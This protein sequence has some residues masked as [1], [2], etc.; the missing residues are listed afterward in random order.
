M[1]ESRIQSVPRDSTVAEIGAPAAA[2]Q[3]T[4]KHFTVT[5]NKRVAGGLALA[6]VRK[7]ITRYPQGEPRISQWDHRF[8]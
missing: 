6:T 7:L 4:P 3:A 5:I 8:D 2:L 1:P